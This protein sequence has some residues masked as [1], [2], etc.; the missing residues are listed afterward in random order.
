[1]S[2]CPGLCEEAEPSSLG[3]LIRGRCGRDSASVPAPAVLG[4]CVHRAD[5]N[6]VRCGAAPA[7]ERDGV[8][9]VPEQE[10][11]GAVLQPCID[12]VRGCRRRVRYGLLG[13]RLDPFDEERAILHRGSPRLTRH[14]TDRTNGR[15]TEDALRH[16][17]AARHS[18][19]CF[20][21]RRERL[22]LWHGSSHAWQLPRGSIRRAR[23]EPSPREAVRAR[24]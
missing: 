18:G 20:P 1:M 21:C 17:A 6:S 15:E 24:G 10:A 14:A 9:V 4:R 16:L 2:R 7:G 23:R 11:A 13:E 3:E 22:D 19:A 8:V 5:P 12:H